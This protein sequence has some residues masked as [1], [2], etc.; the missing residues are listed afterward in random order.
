MTNLEAARILRTEQIGDSEQMELA[1]HMGAKALDKSHM[2]FIAP[3]CEKCGAV[4]VGLELVALPEPAARGFYVMSNIRPSM[5]RC[6]GL[7]FDRVELDTIEETCILRG[8][9]AEQ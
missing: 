2:T 6:C 1:K 3:V 7:M 4:V 5:C 9:G 8:Q